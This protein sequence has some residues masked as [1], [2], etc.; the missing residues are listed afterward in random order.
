MSRGTLLL[1][2]PGLPYHVLDYAINWARENE[3]MLKTV[4]VVPGE[5]PEE[6]YVFPGDLDITENITNSDTAE[7]GVKEIIRQ[8]SRYIERKCNASHV[9]VVIETL[10]SPTAQKLLLYLKDS[11]IIFF[12]KKAKENIDDLKDLP[13]SIAEISEKSKA[14]FI[15]VDEMDKFSDA[16][17]L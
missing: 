9:P 8:E 2:G 5:L 17:F 4:F 13:F 7:E 12:D 1:I 15:A 6:G 3:S 14:Q 16:T 11:E 10:F